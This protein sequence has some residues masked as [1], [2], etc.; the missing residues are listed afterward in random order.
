MK[1]LLS[2]NKNLANN[3]DEN[4]EEELEFPPPPPGVVRNKTSKATGKIDLEQRA[5]E[6]LNE[7]VKRSSQVS[8]DLTRKVQKSSST[9]VGKREYEFEEPEDEKFGR[10]SE[11][12]EGDE[13]G[14]DQYQHTKVIMGK[15]EKMLSKKKDYEEEDE[16]A[17]NNNI[18]VSGIMREMSEKKTDKHSLITKKKTEKST[19]KIES[20]QSGKQDQR[21]FEMSRREKDVKS[22]QMNE[23]E[24]E[25]GEKKTGDE[26]DDKQAQKSV[27][28]RGKDLLRDQKKYESDEEDVLGQHREILKSWGN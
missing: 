19:T 11:E 3:E 24:N 12:E 18:V 6:D 15:V 14:T 5:G 17:E 2:K 22:K 16:E 4:D 26:E 20:S 21:S 7:T 9:K 25:D 27:S 8:S 13:E 1:D 10:S 23:D 28:K